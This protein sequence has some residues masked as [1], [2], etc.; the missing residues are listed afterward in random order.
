MPWLRMARCAGARRPGAG[1][2]ERSG[3][4]DA[5]RKEAHEALLVGPSADAYLVL[6]KLDLQSGSLH[7][8]DSEGADNAL[9]LEPAKSRGAGC[10]A[11]D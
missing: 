4:A 9:K 11:A 2:R 3:D 6:A 8:A 10:D 1:V 7:D 5:A